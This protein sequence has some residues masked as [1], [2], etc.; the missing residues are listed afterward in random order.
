MPWANGLLVEGEVA[1][2]DPH[3]GE[4][5]LF[6]RPSHEADLLLRAG[7]QRHGLELDARMRCKEE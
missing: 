1:R 7:H 6:E 3:V 4:V 2:A 5:E